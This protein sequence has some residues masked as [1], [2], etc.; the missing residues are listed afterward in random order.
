MTAAL[1]GLDVIDRNGREL[2][3]VRVEGNCY[4]A[5]CA[6]PTGRKRGL[7]IRHLRIRD[8]LLTQV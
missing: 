4:F 7:V 3:I 1:K 5:Q 8:R 6:D 2:T